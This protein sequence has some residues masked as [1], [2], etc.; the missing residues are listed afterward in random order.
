MGL[1]DRV[2]N[3]VGSARSKVAAAVEKGVRIVPG[4]ERQIEKQFESVLGDMEAS[5]KPYR[6]EF[7]SLERLPEV[8]RDREAILRDLEKMKDREQDRWK[9]GLVSG[10]VYHGDSDFIDFLCQVYA[11]H[12]QTNPIH[13]DVWPSASKFEAD[14]VAMTANML[15]A[16]STPDEICGTVTSGGSESILMAMKAYRDRAIEQKGISQP[17]I[18]APITAHPAFDKAAQYFQ[19]RM[20]RI[21]TAADFRADVPAMAEA[22]NERTIAV[23]G[24]AP[25]FPHGGIDPIE[26][27]SGLARQRGVGFH[28]DGCLGGFLLPWAEKLGYR[29]PGFDFRL[30]GVTSMSADTHKYGF[31]PKGTSVVLYRGAELRRFQYFTVTDWPGGIYFSPTVAGSRPGGLLAACWAAMVA[32]GKK[33][34]LE[35]ARKILETGRTIRSG[36]ESIPGLRVLGDPLW[37]IAFDSPEFDIYRVLDFMSKRGWSLNGLHR[38]PAVH[39]A[40]TLRHTQAGVAERFLADLRE[41]VDHVKAHPGE[42]GGMAPVYGMAGTL[43][44]RG[45]ISDML[46]RTMDLLYKT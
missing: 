30:P 6:K 12:S 14:I 2:K 11:L 44:F 16:A 41:A 32:T 25:A 4:V 23:I 34:Y 45:V 43:P 40:I 31:A 9:E 20:R 39:L 15:G 38:P 24:S 17:E 27:L 8:G 22:I 28:T 18:V 19:I 3:W 26:E 36:I 42:K 21:P 13:P 10:G 37:I 1:T 33:G 7:P 35:G 5:L 29:V 46:K